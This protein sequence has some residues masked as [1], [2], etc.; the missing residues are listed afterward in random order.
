MFTGK[1][2]TSFTQ[3]DCSQKKI[4]KTR[5]EAKGLRS[6]TSPPIKL[7]NKEISKITEVFS[8]ISTDVNVAF[9]GSRKRFRT[10]GTPGSH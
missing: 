6:R 8:P 1:C 5:F 9:P 7:L 3:N 2:L 10:P 4:L